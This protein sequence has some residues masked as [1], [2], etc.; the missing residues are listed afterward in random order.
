EELEFYKLLE[1]VQETTKQSY[2]EQEEAQKSLHETNISLLESEQELW[3]AT[4]GDTASTAEKTSQKLG[5]LN[6]QLSEQNEIVYG[7]GLTYQRIASEHG[8]DSE[9]A[10]KAL[11]EYNEGLIKL[12]NLS[13]EVKQTVLDGFDDISDE[14]NRSLDA[15]N[16]NYDLWVTLNVD[17]TDVEKANKEIENL[18]ENADSQW[19]DLRNAIGKY[20]TAQYLYPDNNELLTE[21]YKDV[22]EKANAA[23]KTEQSITEKA[24][25]TVKGQETARKEFTKLLYS[26]T[27]KFF[28]EIGYAEEQIEKWAREQ[29]GY[30]P[31]KILETGDRSEYLE[32]LEKIL[33][34]RLG[35]SL[36]EGFTPN[37]AAKEQFEKERSQTP[38][39]ESV[40]AAKDLIEAC[41]TAVKDKQPKWVELGTYLVDGFIQGIK[42]KVEEAAQAAAEMAA[43][44]YSAAKAELEINSPSKAFAQLGKFTDIGF[45]QGISK[46]SDSAIGASSDMAG[47]VLSGFSNIIGQVAEFANSDMDYEPTIRPVIDASNIEKGASYINGVL[48][49]SN[50]AT[51]DVSASVRKTIGVDSAQSERFSDRNLIKA[52]NEMSAKLDERLYSIKESTE[53]LQVVIDSGALVGQITPAINRRL[54]RQSSYQERGI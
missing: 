53:D 12:R 35:D 24:E 7:L 5:N 2:E 22:Q 17:A 15:L 32:E 9:D 1:S 37:E 42:S 44:A 23:A 36:P 25:Q 43:R 10:R 8:N 46:Y 52:I 26:D 30:D 20:Q 14:I 51:L 29:S 49:S 18:N 28:R 48:S 16:A 21:L 31:T 3:E 45:A 19:A 54:G 33:A 47:S 40:D 41:E 27:A 34:M 50:R 38:T 6:K 4:Y 11:Q 13:N 39:D